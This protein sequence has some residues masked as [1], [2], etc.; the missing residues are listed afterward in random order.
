LFGPRTPAA[1]VRKLA[2]A[3]RGC[4]RPKHHDGT[5]DRQVFWLTAHDG[6]GPP[7]RGGRA[8]VALDCPRAWPI[9]AAAPRRI[10]TGFPFH[11]RPKERVGGPVVPGTIIRGRRGAASGVVRVTRIRSLVHM[12]ALAKL[13]NETEPSE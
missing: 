2:T 11:R 6:R 12:G 10:L 4:S 1:D 7:S 8:P 5:T 9:T 3:A 13:P